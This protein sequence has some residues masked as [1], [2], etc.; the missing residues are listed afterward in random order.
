MTVVTFNIL[1]VRAPVGTFSQSGKIW[2]HMDPA[3]LP[4]ETVRLLHRNGL[5][6]ARGRADAW[7]PIRAILET[8]PRVENAQNTLTVNNGLPLILELDR[9]PKDQLLFLYRRDG[10][11]A[12]APWKASTNLLRIV[13]GVP[14]NAP[15]G[16]LL[17]IAPELRLDSPAAQAPRGIERWDPGREQA[18]RS[19][20]IGELAFRVQLAPQEFVAIGPSPATR[21]VP[22]IMGSLFLTEE[23][24]GERLESMYL[25][26]PT[27]SHEGG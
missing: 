15:D 4:G 7:A 23:R 20:V 25:I 9:Q 11:L 27:V 1:H 18:G 12:G 5:V 8:E 22:Y 17:E 16:L 10:T 3:F 6:V 2:N 24:Q 13:Y 14:P 21:E 26:T 19:L